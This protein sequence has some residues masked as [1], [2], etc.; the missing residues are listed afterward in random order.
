MLGLV[1][2]LQIPISHGVKY[3]LTFRSMVVVRRIFEF[4]RVVIQAQLGLMV[5]P[6]TSVEVVSK[7]DP[8]ILKILNNLDKHSLDVPYDSFYV[9]QFC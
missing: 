7:N 4:L 8:E 9:H 3:F 6:K 1:F 5:A 2:A